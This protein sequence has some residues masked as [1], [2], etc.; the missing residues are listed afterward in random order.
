MQKYKINGQNNRVTFK[1]LCT[2]L[3]YNKKKTGICVL[4]F[5]ILSTSLCTSIKCS[6]DT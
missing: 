2:I 4:N 3:M 5:I 6:Y 1:M